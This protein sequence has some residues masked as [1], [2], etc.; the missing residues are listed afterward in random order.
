MEA[1]QK[2]TIEVPVALLDRARE[3][4]GKGVTATVREGLR[5]VAAARAYRELRLLRGRVRLRQ[6]AAT[7]RD[8]RA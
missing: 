3:A 7:L 6:N 5:L 1:L 4:S 2:I 8:D